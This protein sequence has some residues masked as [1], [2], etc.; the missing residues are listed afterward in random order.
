MIRD[1]GQSHEVLYRSV[2]KEKF[3]PV[4]SVK[5]HCDG[6]YFNLRVILLFVMARRHLAS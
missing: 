2:E 3:I 4:D 5:L 1:K 6:N